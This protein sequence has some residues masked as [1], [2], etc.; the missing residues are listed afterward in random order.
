MHPELLK[1][2]PIVIHSYG[3]MIA[4]GF[5]FAILLAV[6]RSKRSGLNTD[7]IFGLAIYGIIGGFAGAKLLF[8]AI[9]I[10][11]IY[12]HPS[13]LLDLPNGFV[14]FGGLIGG[15]LTG[16]LY[17]RI[18][19]V[20]FI[21]YFDLVVPSIALAQGFGRIGCF[22]AGCCYGRETNSS[23]GIVFKDS[24]YAPNGV[25]LIPTQ[26]ISSIGD[27]LIVIIL[28]FYARR[29][30][31]N[32]KLAGLYLILYSVGR[33]FI[34]MLRDDPRGFIGI[35]SS[36]QIISIFTLIFGL[37]LFNLSKFKIITLKLN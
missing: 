23:L 35:L 1:F 3:F 32:G 18:K 21:E 13:I 6:Y 37:F 22:L 12:L 33:F 4:I 24:L 25:R 27:F 36:S 10:K 34:E 19:K 7:M 17:C 8:V 5:L 11:N 9:E 29:K 26:I 14:V 30:R 20:D 31:Q 28:L 16:Y 15:I 2:G